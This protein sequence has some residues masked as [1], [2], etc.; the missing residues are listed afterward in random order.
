MA[1]GFNKFL[2][3]GGGDIVGLQDGTEI[4]FSSTISA[5]NLLP[6]RA[7]RTDPARVIQSGDLPISDITGLQ[8]SLD[9]K[10][11]N[12]MTANLDGGQFNIFDLNNIQIDTTGS[13]TDIATLE[14]NGTG[15]VT[16]EL[17][18]LLTSTSAPVVDESVIVYDGTTGALIKETAANLTV[19]GN[20]SGLT[21]LTSSGN[22]DFSP[23]DSFDVTTGD[24][25]AEACSLQTSGGTSAG[26]RLLN[27]TGTAASS[28]LID[29]TA[30][31]IQL[32][33][34]SGV[35]VAS[36]G[37]TI[38]NNP[39]AASTS[40]PVV[41]ES[42]VVYDGTGGS[43]IKETSGILTVAGAL[44]GLTALTSSGGI[45]F[46]P[47]TTF[48]VETSMNAVNAC[49][50]E[51]NGGTSTTMLIKNDSGTAV[52]SIS[53]DS[54]A[55]G[56]QL[57]SDSGVNVA[58]GGFTIANNP[59][60]VSTSAP[61]VTNSI[62]KY[63]GTGGSLVT[64]SSVTIDSGQIST[65]ENILINTIDS[66]EDTLYGFDTGTSI[67]GSLNTIF[68]SEAGTG[69]IENRNCYFGRRAAQNASGGS[70]NTCLGFEA[71]RENIGPSHNTFIGSSTGV[72]CT[73]ASN[74]ALGS[75]TFSVA[76]GGINN[77][78]LGRAAGNAILTGSDNICIG[79]QAGSDYKTSESDNICIGN[80]GTTGE[81]G[82]IR[83]GNS[84]DHDDCFIPTP[85]TISGNVTIDTVDSSSNTFYG[86][87]AGVNVNLI[88]NTVIGSEAG[89]AA[90]NNN[91]TLI[92]KW[93]GENATGSSQVVV[94]ESAGRNMGSGL[95]CVYVGVL[96]GN[97]TTGNDNVAIGAAAMNVTTSAVGNTAIGRNALSSV[98]TGD[99]NTALGIDA[100]SALTLTDSD[101]ICIGNVGVVGDN[102]II[103][104]G[105][106]THDFVQI[107]KELRIEEDGGGNYTGFRTSTTQPTDY[108]YQMPIAQSSD[109]Q[110]RTITTR[111]GLLTESENG[112]YGRG[113]IY[114]GRL[115]H[116]SDSTIAASNCDCRDDSNVKNLFR[117]TATIDF[118]TS[119][120]LGIQT[121][122]APISANTWYGIHIIG[123]TT[124]SN[125]DT[126]IAI[127]AGSALSQT[128]YDVK[129]R[130][131]HVRSNASSDLLNFTMHHR[132]DI[133]HTI[134]DESYADLELFSAGPSV[135]STL[136]TLD[137][138]SL[139]PPSC[140]MA[141]FHFEI[142]LDDD[143]HQF[144]VQN[145]NSGQTYA[146]CVI[147]L[148]TGI[149]TAPGEEFNTVVSNLGCNSSQEIEWGA[150]I[151]GN[152]ITITCVAYF[153]NL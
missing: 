128:G 95:N 102:A 65:P 110:R 12:P 131:G 120:I 73:G 92:G 90:L 85:L 89:T 64:E 14:Y 87:D 107:P 86:F 123:D 81:S 33:S 40:A 28:I 111:N 121:D 51:S 60:V 132:G 136:Q 125:A 5:S 135:G 31:G 71:G 99:R 79:T 145:P 55:G 126:F 32:D 75:G 49:S 27:N 69:I 2:Q 26:I 127:E 149:E 103:R 133:R 50:I 67:A 144:R 122:D 9:S 141:D 84:T 63:S 7:L 115:A 114:D 153:E 53:I 116:L 146:N 34:S 20:L 47:C 18:G 17:D 46:D 134:W 56:I 25:V 23:C 101:N 13:G 129:R 70:D 97:A 62:V 6:S 143:F 137:C 21:R 36:G 16:I 148:G 118:A 72:L 78:M 66:G 24:N 45:D 29:S 42:V 91:N 38:A 88:G 96:A 48:S 11:T 124:G 150:T 22:I 152:F 98:T 44:S 82:K 8:A 117:S 59:V 77:C 119:G 76:T 93:A 4:L 112:P 151:T 19:A 52:N 104:I 41:N 39:A 130:L 43:L 61:V 30:G 10:L 74:V 138:S 37:F 58:S 83:I 94:G 109:D 3:S 54:T 142:D 108:T 1:S 140:S 15:N 100:G 106:D 57:D 139:L 80:D 35:N 105:N 68:G 113:F 147:R